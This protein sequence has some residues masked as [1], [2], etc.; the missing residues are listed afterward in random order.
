MNID[1]QLSLTSIARKPKILFVAFA[2][3]THT[4]S[5]VDLMTSTNFD[6]RVF[7]INGTIAPTGFPFRVISTGMPHKSSWLSEYFRCR[8][9]KTGR[10]LLGGSL[11]FKF[12]NYM[13]RNFGQANEWFAGSEQ[14]LLAHIILTWKPDIIHTLGIEFSALLFQRIRKC[15][16]LEHVGTWVVSAW[17]GSD[18]DLV[19]FDPQYSK[20]L[21][22]VTS[23]CDYFIADNDLAYSY[24]K[25]LGLDS[26]KIIA[27]GQTP[28][29][30]GVEVD[31]LRSLRTL[32]PSQQRAIL[33]PKAY[34]CP[35]S[36]ILPVFEALKLCWEQISPCTIV[37]TACNPEAKSWFQALP[38]SIRSCSVL[39]DRIPHEQL[40]EIMADSRIVLAP[41]LIDGI[42]NALYEAMATGAFP[43]FSPLETFRNI[44]SDGKNILYARNL[45]PDEIASA[46]IK[47]MSD[48]DLVDSAVNLNQKLVHSL[49][50]RSNVRS[51]V[52]NFYNS[53]VNYDSGAVNHV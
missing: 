21:S 37:M 27:R 34:E 30:G 33:M 50:E 17:G 36:K 47:A 16:N 49:A 38:E 9:A 18:F 31:K 6:V 4:H 35:F 22:L 41:S 7:G 43:I 29:A 39:K 26:S 32:M 25:E 45:Y 15:Y 28:G 10:V 24:A 1:C 11:Q 13:A 44:L 12:L 48:D 19:R 42:P 5:W 53:I 46:L 14:E 52:I 8:I 2:H 23:E 3:S 51:D 20:E 40:L